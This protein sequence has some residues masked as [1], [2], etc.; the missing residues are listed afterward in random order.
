MPGA[1]RAPPRPCACPFA[2]GVSNHLRLN[3]PAFLAAALSSARIGAASKPVSMRSLY[4][5]HHTS[6]DF[7]TVPRQLLR[8]KHTHATVGCY[9]GSARSNRARASSHARHSFHRH[10]PSILRAAVPSAGRRACARRKDGACGAVRTRAR[11]SACNSRPSG[12]RR[13]RAPTGTRCVAAAK[14]TAQPSARSNR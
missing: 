12:A 1:A 9:R 10:F 2:R 5:R 11:P 3:R 7:L 6:L 8:D 14:G 4:L 13:G